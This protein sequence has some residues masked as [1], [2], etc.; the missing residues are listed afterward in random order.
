MWMVSDG[1]LRATARDMARGVS[2]LCGL[3]SSVSKSL[4]LV[5]RTLVVV[6]REA[7]AL[8]MA[9]LLLGFIA[10]TYL[11]SQAGLAGERSEVAKYSEAK[12]EQVHLNYNQTKVVLITGDTRMGEVLGRLLSTAKGVNYWDSP[13]KFCWEKPKVCLRE[14]G[15]LHSLKLLES[16][17]HCQL[18][19]LAVLQD[20]LGRGS[21]EDL[22][23][24]CSTIQIQL[25]RSTRLRV[26][27]VAFLMAENP[28]L[29]IF[30]LYLLRDPRASLA[31]IKALGKFRERGGGP[32][33]V[34]GNNSYKT[35]IQDLC[36]LVSDDIEH[37]AGK[38]VRSVRVESVRQEDL[39]LD[40]EQEL[41]QVMRL[42]GLRPSQTTEEMVKKLEFPDIQLE[43]HPREKIDLTMA[44]ELEAADRWKSVLSPNEIQYLERDFRCNQ[45]LKYGGYDYWDFSNDETS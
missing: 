23:R 31:D 40:L 33:K 42:T 19:F 35:V 44:D 8:V 20:W 28:H 34:Y 25:I 36:T 14:L 7:P 10:T 45:V 16:L 3:I 26:R 11:V 41:R 32:V 15:S 37:L 17:F 22:V 24:R 27:D 21:L 9:T 18:R 43:E 12:W 1:L 39:L 30:T 13:L 5:A 6:A 2:E 4:G 29:R 38:H